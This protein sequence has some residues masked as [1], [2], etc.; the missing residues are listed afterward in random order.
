MIR[1]YQRIRYDDILT[2]ASSEDDN[3]GYII[4]RQRLAIPIEA[5]CQYF[6]ILALF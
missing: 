2:P 4:W 1:K 3:F 6:S 5:C